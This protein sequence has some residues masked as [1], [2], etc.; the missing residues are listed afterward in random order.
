MTTDDRYFRATRH[1]LRMRRLDVA[2][3][4]RLTPRMVRVTLTGDDLDG[5]H[6]DGPADHVKLFAPAEGRSDPELPRLGPDGIEPDPDRPRPVGRDYT[7]RLAPLAEGRLEL[8][9]F[10]HPGGHASGWAARAH[11]GDVVGIG[12]PRGSQVLLPGL[13]RVVLV[14]DETALPAIDNFLWLLAGTGCHTTVI[15]EIDGPAE[16]RD[17]DV[18]PDA[19]HWIPR[20]TAPDAAPGSR[21]ADAVRRHVTP[22]SRGLHWV[23]TETA[24]AAVVRR[25]LVD[26]LGI[27]DEDIR[28][29]GYWRREASDHHEPH[30]D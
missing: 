17:F 15:A 26:E 3:V 28:S 1:E 10:L 2:D 16:V 6:S 4:S 7:P 19:V 25:V 12:G 24:D 9:L 8:D 14:G 13:E 29:R 11:V 20:D 18:V 5:F 27:A 30:V 23:A 22:G 21:L